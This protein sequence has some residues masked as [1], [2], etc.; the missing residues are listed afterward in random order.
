MVAVFII[1][2]KWKEPTSLS[3][4]EYLNKLS[5]ISWNI[6]QQRREQMIYTHKSAKKSQKFYVE[7][8]LQSLF[9]MW[10]SVAI[11][12]TSDD[13]GLGVA[14]EEERGVVIKGRC[15]ECVMTQVLIGMGW[16]A[17]MTKVVIYA[18][19]KKK[20]A[21]VVNSQMIETH[22]EIRSAVVC[23]VTCPPLCDRMDC[24]QAGS[25]AHGI[26]QTRIFK[27]VAVSSSRNKKQ[28]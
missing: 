11:E 15:R 13:Q 17:G 8:K 18:V 21:E 2:E 26:L 24:R 1:V 22:D 16:Q 12:K 19:K 14:A 23:L 9:S 28:Q 20:I 5:S 6:T 10:K 25:S 4:S 7:R 27:R 3:I